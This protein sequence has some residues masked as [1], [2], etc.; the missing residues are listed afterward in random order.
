L[1][2]TTIISV[3]LSGAGAARDVDARGAALGLRC[4]SA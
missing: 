4:T 2:A 3:L 1:Q